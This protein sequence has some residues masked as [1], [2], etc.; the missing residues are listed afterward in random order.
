MKT[1][2]LII[3]KSLMSQAIDLAEAHNEFHTHYVIGGR[4]ALYE[5]LASIMRFTV[6]VNAS[7]E[8][9]ALIQSIRHELQNQYNIKTQ[10][11]SSTTA[12]LVKYITRADRKTT[13]VYARAIDTAIA[14]NIKA[15]DFVEFAETEGGIEQ[16]RAIGVDA[17]VKEKAETVA[18]EKFVLAEEYLIAREE[19]PFEVLDSKL[20][21][22]DSECRYE[23]LMCIN[24]GKQ[25]HVVMKVPAD[26]A[27]EERAIKLT[28]DFSFKDWEKDSKACRKFIDAAN[29][30]RAERIAEDRGVKMERERANK[31]AER[32]KELAIA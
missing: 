10:A 29:I 1:T 5:M 17:E 7:I 32:T 21:R 30:K 2:N 14:S 28:G 12:I 26:K 20:Y 27:F 6:D 23:Y 31:E 22:M 24:T 8:K 25:L 13:H 3:T 16:I 4:K 11:N 18:N 19:I 15:D 9:D